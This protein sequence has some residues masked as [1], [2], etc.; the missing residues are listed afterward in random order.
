MDR[1]R[2]E[3]IALINNAGLL[4]PVK[5]VHRASDAELIDHLNVNLIGPMLLTSI[6]I[7]KVLAWPIPKTI[8]NISSGAAINPYFGW[9]PY[10]S[11]KAGLNM[12]AASVGMEQSYEKFPVKVFSV[13][14]GIVETSMQEL[15]RS[16]DE[17][18]F[19]Y[20]QKFIELKKQGELADPDVTGKKLADLIFSDQVEQGGF[21][22]LRY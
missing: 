16:T 15:I 12:F 11:S 3:K 18:D 17:K 5:P 6:F 4:A 8:M 1:N 9:S 21:T 14:P 10:C 20:K 22:D 19:V 13:A 7:K 2:T